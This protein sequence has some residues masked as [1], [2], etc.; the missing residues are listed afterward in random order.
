MRKADNLTTVLC[1]CHEIW[2]LPGT[3]L[4]PLRHSRPVTGLFLFLSKE[5]GRKV[6]WETSVIFKII[7]SLCSRRRDVGKAGE[8]RWDLSTAMWIQHFRSHFSHIQSHWL[9]NLPKMCFLFISNIHWN[10]TNCQTVQHIAV[11][12]AQTKSFVS[13]RRPSVTHVELLWF[14]CYHLKGRVIP[15]ILLAH[16]TRKDTGLKHRKRIPGYLWRTEIHHSGLHILFVYIRYRLLLQIC[17]SNQ[18]M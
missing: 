4:N 15:T 12:T 5:S 6:V 10:G 11:S 16:L 9:H 2:E 3:S 14:I 1:R 7:L 8:E 13:I 17:N 18:N